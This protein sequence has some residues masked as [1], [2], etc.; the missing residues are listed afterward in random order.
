MNSENL[1]QAELIMIHNANA[2]S[3]KLFQDNQDESTRMNNEK[4]E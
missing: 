3:Q 1:Y 2:N 4:S